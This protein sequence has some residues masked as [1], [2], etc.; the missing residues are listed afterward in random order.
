MALSFSTE[1]GSPRA[2]PASGLTEF[3][4]DYYGWRKGNR[5]AI[6]QSIRE[7]VRGRMHLLEP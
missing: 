5:Q 1:L 4:L 3:D 7:G 6:L 2:E